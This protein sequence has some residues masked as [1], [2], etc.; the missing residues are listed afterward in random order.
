MTD[1]G[2]PFAVMAP[3]ALLLVCYPLLPDGTARELGYPAI[4]LVCAAVGFAGLVRHLSGRRAGWHLV[5]GGFLGWVVGD[6]LY[7]VEQRGFALE[8]YPA[9]SDGVYIA[10]YAVL[11][12]GLL[13]LVRRRGERSDVAAMLDGAILAAGVAVVVGVFLLAPIANDSSLSPLGKLTSSLYPIADVL[14]IGILVRLWTTP[15]AR[16]TAF[17]LLAAALSMTLLADL[18][19]NVTTL[20][21]GSLASLLV[22]DVCWLGGYVLA[23]GAA[24]SSS[25]NDLTELSPGREDLT[26]PTRR[27]F[28]L[29][30]GLLLPGIT[31]L[32]D[33]IPDGE[34]HWEIVAAGAVLLS[35][36]VLARMAGLLNV[37]RVQAVQLAGLARSDPLTG[38]ANRR[39]WDHELSRA[40]QL[41]R[42]SGEP[43]CVALLDLDHFKAYNDRHGHQ[44]GDRLLREAT[45]MWTTLLGEGAML[46]R[47]GGEEFAVL[48]SGQRLAAAHARVIELL[49]HMPRGATASAGVA[50]WDP[51]SDPSSVVGLADQ[52][53][54][55]AKRGGRNQALSAEP[56]SVLELPRPSIVHQPIVDLT[57]SEPVAV[58]ALSRFV[59]GPPQVVFDQARRDGS[60]PAL[61]ASAI[62]AALAD[63]PAGVMLSLNVGVDTLT[64]PLVRA[65]LAGDLTG[66]ILEIT[67]HTDLDDDVEV[68]RAIQEYRS[69]GAAIAVDDWGKGYSDMGRLMFLR[70]DIVKLDM[71]LVHG[72]GSTYHVGAVRAAVAW[73]DAV[74]A[75]L[76]AEGIETDEQL[77]ALRG[78]GVH[79]GQGFLIGRPAPSE[80]SA[81]SA[82]P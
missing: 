64:S 78:L 16:T 70:P 32:V 22:S 61:E 82:A 47:Y 34:V 41:A 19:Y 59:E 20:T 51:T 69:R 56:G 71:S 38:V 26:D 39:T 73:A 72:I 66:V 67:E 4:G 52:A 15:G 35:L 43:L 3:L 33:G 21:S 36:L 45:A 14:M 53:L 31:L 58:E 65:A 7:V 54:Y 8:A 48:F 27:M 17:R 77:Q 74:G 55:A 23:A 44:A 25:V 6:V 57:T 2:R 28:V 63:R 46:A 9:P 37:V 42:T 75:K 62:A 13:V 50:Q 11:A 49:A 81:R 24:W 60:G 29:T 68:G 10:S 18:I 5:L 12:W 76:C 1:R 40:C 80:P 79:Y 30:G